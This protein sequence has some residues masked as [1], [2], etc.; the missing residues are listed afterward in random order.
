[1]PGNRWASL[2]YSLHTSEIA[3]VKRAVFTLS[4]AAKE[5]VTGILLRPHMASHTVGGD[6]VIL[7]R[8]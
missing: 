6:D 5:V 4:V 7:R 8:S 3:T 1:M 2:L